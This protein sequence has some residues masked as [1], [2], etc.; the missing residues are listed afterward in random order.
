MNNDV[1]LLNYDG[2]PLSMIPLST[3]TWKDA[4]RLIFL[5]KG[6]VVEY[7][8]DW[9][10]HS[11]REGYYVPSVIMIRRYVKR[12]NSVHLNKA[13]L[14]LRD[15]YRCQYCG[16]QFQYSELTYDHMIPVSKG[17]IST[18][19]NLVAACKSCNSN[20]SD[21]IVEPRHIPYQPTY[22][23][24]LK[25]RVKA[26]IVISHKSWERFITPGEGGFVLQKPSYA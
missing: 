24:L 2:Q 5:D 12:R 22:W 25:V 23:D 11:A 10:V 17:G 18:W 9:K 7:Y 6:H 1:L 20:K 19:D 3:I 4:M 13:N 15:G 16:G 8:E 21:K 14:Y 26:P